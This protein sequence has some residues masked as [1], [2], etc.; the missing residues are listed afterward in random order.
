MKKLYLLAM[1]VVLATAASAGS[2]SIQPVTI[3]D[4]DDGTGRAQGSMSTAR[5][6]ENDIEV[7]GCGTRVW[8]GGFRNGFCQATDADDNYRV[9]YTENPVLLDNMRATGDYS[10]VAF[11]W[12][13][14][15]PDPELDPELEP[16]QLCTFVQFSTQSFYIPEHG[17]KSKKSKKSSK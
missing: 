13:T 9:C 16:F 17:K 15:E 3:T 1:V 14:I 2:I 11:E 4:N 5:F 10:F 8:A 6:S 12:E 7:M